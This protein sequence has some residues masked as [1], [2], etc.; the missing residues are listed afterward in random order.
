MV[1]APNVPTKEMAA[2]GEGGHSDPALC[3]CSH[4]YWRPMTRNAL[5]LSVRHRPAIREN[6]SLAA[7]VYR[8]LWNVRSWSA[9]TRICSPDAGN[10][11][12]VLVDSTNVMICQPLVTGPRHD[13]E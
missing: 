3:G 2:T 8:F 9:W 7:A 6:G 5:P 11:A 10:R 12:Q 4:F 1:V 13:L